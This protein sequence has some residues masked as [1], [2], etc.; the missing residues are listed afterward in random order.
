MND[1]E[2]AELRQLIYHGKEE[3]NLEYKQS[4][5]WASNEV[6]AKITKRSWP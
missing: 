3:R 4:L 2:L 6:K 1:L 5:S